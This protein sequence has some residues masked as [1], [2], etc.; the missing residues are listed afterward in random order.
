MNR[1]I[2][3]IIEKTIRAV[4]DPDNDDRFYMP[5]VT[6]SKLKDGTRVWR[7]VGRGTSNSG[8]DYLWRSDGKV[9]KRSPEGGRAVVGDEQDE[10]FQLGGA[11][12]ILQYR[13]LSRAPVELERELEAA[14]VKVS[15]QA[16]KFSVGGRYGSA[17]ADSISAKLDAV[18]AAGLEDDPA[19]RALVKVMG[20]L[21]PLDRAARRRVLEFALVTIN[22]LPAQKDGE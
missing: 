16:F 1:S 14:A 10:V 5:S 22:G 8:G 11:L 6:S 13:V 17:H 12:M 7:C 3:D 9:Y 21:A 4:L 20:A 2:T 18:A 19:I 15:G